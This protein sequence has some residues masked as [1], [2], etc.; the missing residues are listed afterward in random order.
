MRQSSRPGDGGG[1]SCAAVDAGGAY[2]EGGGSLGPVILRGMDDDKVPRNWPAI[3][4]LVCASILAL[5]AVL[6]GLAFA[7]R[8]LFGTYN[9]IG[10]YRAVGIDPLLRSLVIWFRSFF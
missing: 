6:I 5:P 1:V 4:I 7:E 2:R 3:A 8:I 9:L 10:I